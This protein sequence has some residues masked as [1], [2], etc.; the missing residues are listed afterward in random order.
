MKR[1]TAR[2]WLAALPLLA[3][4]LL[5]GALSI[6]PK[7]RDATVARVD[8]NRD[9]RP[10]FNG[11]CMGC[12]GGVKQAGNV[13]F[14]YREQALGKGKSGRPTV[15]PG[16]PRQS[17]LMARVTS[18]N[19]ETRMPLNRAPLKPGQIALLKQWIEEGA[20][21]QNYWAFVSPRPQALPDVKD[22]AW[23]RQ[24]L[25]RFILAR[26][27][28]EKLRPSPE[29]G[30]AALLRRVSLDL[31]GLPPTPQ[32]QNAFL[33]DTSSN[34]YERQVDRL[35]A[36]PAFGE[37]WASLW[38]DLARYGDTKGFEKD[39]ARPGSWIYRDWVVDAINRNMPYDDFVIRQIAGDLLPNASFSDRI[40]T[41]FHRQTPANDEGGTDNEE[42]R[43]QAIMD[44]AS[45]T[46]SVLNG[47]SFNCVQCHSHPYDPIRH[48]EFYKFLAFFNT[49]RDADIAFDKSLDEDWPVLKVP[50]DRKQFAQADQLQ[51]EISALR[52]GLVRESR[53]ASDATQ[54]KLQPIVKGSVTEALALERAIAEL[55]QQ[56]TNDGRAKQIAQLSRQLALARKVPPKAHFDLQNGMAVQRGT[57][58]MNS[59][60]EFESA[61]N[62]SRL[63]ALRIEVPPADPKKAVH[64]PERGFVSNR[65]DAWLVHAD[66]A[67]DKIGF[68]ILAPDSVENVYGNIARMLR[69]APTV[70]DSA[71][72]PSR[73]VVNGG[74]MAN[75]SLFRTR[76]VVAVPDKPLDLS[77]GAVLRVQL[78][79]TELINAASSAPPRVRLL[80]TD[81]IRWSRLG[82]SQSFAHA[83][84]QL[85]AKERQLAKIP[86]LPLPVMVEQGA[87]ERRQTL[88][89]DRGS[90][91][92]QMGPALE[93]GV[94]AV[95][96]ELPPGKP[97][98]RLTLARWF[99]SPGQ[100][101][102]ARVA[103]NRYWEQLFGNGL[104]ESLEDFG[105]AG[106]MPSHP[107][108]LDWLAL[109]FQKDLRWNVKA[110]LRELVTSATYR[111]KAVATEALLHRDP[112]NRLLAHG[113][114][115]RLT[116]EMVRDQAL[117]ASG[118]LNGKIGGKPVMPLQPEGVWNVEANN[119]ERWVNSTGPDRFRRALYT[120]VKRT[121]MYPSFMTFDAADR[122]LSVP[123]RLPTNTPLQALVTLNDPVYQEVAEALGARMNRQPGSLDAKLDVGA[124]WVL[125]RA[126]SAGEQGVLTKLYRAE[127]M[128]AVASALLNLDA[129]LTR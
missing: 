7:S 112:R 82:A 11:N 45:T 33:A 91:L 126:L 21:W 117:L 44:R 54:W 109:H 57:V 67:A 14:S 9:I 63:T 31:T 111:Q 93:P 47:V 4:C 27:E 60:Y 106:E 35:L 92:T 59:V 28:T 108:L 58:P 90:F 64:S 97:R 46:W 20:L 85:E 53:A 66:G 86:A 55:A 73:Y 68:R 13:S 76:W 102:T 30:K 100:P 16:S 22:K 52:E 15:V 6:W 23:I 89:F 38:L 12:H 42:F 114:Q 56:T 1:P 75:P 115:Q 83:L 124:H 128:T 26:L 39:R 32:E 110:L 105:S 17:E 70:A 5:V 61:P 118:L 2:I 119:P 96:P 79:H 62:L 71:S 78:T 127:G 19:P 103:V 94:P 129:A 77:K 99:F 10:I 3:V 104:V 81:D 18:S 41:A 74:L 34:A 43:L 107:E 122:Q 123:R 98:D 49:T 121:A 37:R 116:A 69:N 24:P 40:A 101:L 113:P 80:G 8:F 25:D 65:I 84:A 125:S 48:T 95:F 51:R 120:F 72:A 36:S 87:P 88:E 29:A 50:T